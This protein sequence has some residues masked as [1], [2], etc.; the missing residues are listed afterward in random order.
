M[1]GNSLLEQYKGVD[2]STMTENK[3]KSGQVMTIFDNM[4][5]DYRK[6]LRDNLQ[7]TTLAQHMTESTVEKR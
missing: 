4:L 2:L 6:K 7:N 5:E 1:Q 3:L